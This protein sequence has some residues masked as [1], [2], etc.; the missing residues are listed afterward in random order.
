MTELEKIGII[1]FG[2]LFALLMIAGRLGA[3]EKAS[4]VKLAP[5]WLERIVFWE[6]KRS[7]CPGQ[8]S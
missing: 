2:V 5:K 3:A 8:I 4:G 1:I 7:F 6:R